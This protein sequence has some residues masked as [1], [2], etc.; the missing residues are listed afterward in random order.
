MTTSYHTLTTHFDIESMPDYEGI[1]Q[2][3]LQGFDSFVAA[4]KYQ[5][6]R[7]VLQDETSSQT[8]AS[9]PGFVADIVRHV[10]DEALLEKPYIF[11]SV[12]PTAMV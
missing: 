3:F 6:V 2:R 8:L 7:A 11:L 4:K 12:T 9:N 10:D 1:R 5:A